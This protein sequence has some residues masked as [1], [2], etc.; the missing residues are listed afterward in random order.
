MKPNAL[1]GVSA[2]VCLLVISGCGKKPATTAT[3]D[4]S[5]AVDATD[6]AALQMEQNRNAPQAQ[7]P[8]P[9]N[10]SCP[11]GF[12][13]PKNGADVRGIGAGTALDQAILY[14]KCQD[15]ATPY[16]VSDLGP[17]FKD[18]S[19]GA[20]QLMRVTDGTPV[21][22]NPEH[23]MQRQAAR[24]NGLNMDNY[25]NVHNDYYLL[26]TGATGAETVSGVWYTETFADGKNP[27]TADSIKALTVKYGKPSEDQ[28]SSSMETLRW[29][30]DA[31]GQA[32]TPDSPLYS[33]CTSVAPNF[34]AVSLNP[35]CGLTIRADIAKVPT[36]ELLAK[37]ISYGF[38]NQAQ[39]SAALDRQQQVD[40][41][42]E[43]TRKQAEAKAATGNGPR[44]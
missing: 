9:E 12:S 7:Q 16:Q 28:N 18:G 1:F 5:L 3:N 13:L 24:R 17:L 42:N 35:N 29:V 32:L 6:V 27:T 8:K 39:M 41:T 20:R 25:S 34:R 33:Q 23:W 10:L 19:P 11:F 43:A 4:N 44:L 36:N 2:A 26:A 30:F 38:V 21:G 15:K 31:H 14:A 22:D 37:S 40:A